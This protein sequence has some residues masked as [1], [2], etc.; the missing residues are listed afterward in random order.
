MQVLTTIAPIFAVITLGYILRING[1]ISKS[2]LG[3]AN[4][5]VFYFALPALVF[6]AVSKASFQKDF[7]SNVLFVTI[8]ATTS[9]YFCGWLITRFTSWNSA[10]IRSFILCVGHGNL[11]YIGIPVAFYFLGEKGFT[12]AAI[13]A[14]FLFIVQN[15]LS[16]LVMQANGVAEKPS[17]NKFLSLIQSLVSNPII[18]SAFAGMAVSL[19]QLPLPLPL[20]RFLEIMS[21]LAAPMSLLLIG[22]SLSFTLLRK[23]IYTVFGTAAIKLIIL[24]ILGIVPFLLLGIEIDDY[25]P[26]LILLATPT[27]TVVY[28]MAGEMGGDPDFTAAAVSASTVCSA[29]TYVIWLTAAS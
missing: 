22:A 5:I 9:M 1:F 2:F 29:I 28:I 19:L 3:P 14:G 6:S 8:A 10:R 12:K 11:A 7:N 25:L 26:A 21:G 15:M 16:V 23:N 13:L 20:L 18:L 4:K 24:P 17:D 27:A